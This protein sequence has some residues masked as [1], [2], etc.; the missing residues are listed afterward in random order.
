MLTHTC[1]GAGAAMRPAGAAILRDVLVA[2]RADEVGPVDV[3]PVPRLGQ[4][5]DVQVLMGPR[6]SSGNGEE[7]V[8][9]LLI[10]T[11]LS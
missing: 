10:F 5:R 7:P 8:N 2:S 1:H 4:V 11:N 9:F 6:T 3:P